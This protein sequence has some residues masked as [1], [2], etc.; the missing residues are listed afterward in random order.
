MKFIFAAENAEEL[1]RY[2]RMTNGWA[3]KISAYTA[4]LKERYEVRELPRCVVFA[5]LETAT[6]LVS[7]IPI[8]AYTNDCRIMMCPELAVWRALY[9]KQIEHLDASLPSVQTIRAHYDALTPDHLLQILGHE[10][11][12]H[13]ALFADDFETERD[14]GIWFEEGMVEYISMKYFLSDADF[15]EQKRISALLV[16]LLF[17]RY[18]SEPL[19]SF[20][21]ATYQG[22][23]NGVWFDYHRS[24]LAVDRL[25]SALGSVG[26]VF[27][28]YFRWQKESPETALD[29]WFGVS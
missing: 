29:V 11:A 23:L 5:S 8:P 20:G 27:E 9:Q 10:L 7:D 4:F 12:H 6:A 25:V 19:S 13:S 1:L 2:Q 14:D 17:E 21:K 18:G 16:E 26:A 24:F 28:N 3:E 15:E 22:E